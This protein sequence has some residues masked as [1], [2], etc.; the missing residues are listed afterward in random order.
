MKPAGGVGPVPLMVTVV[1]PG[2]V[3]SLKAR[4]VVELGAVVT[5]PLGLTSVF[6]YLAT[7]ILA[8]DGPPGGTAPRRV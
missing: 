6:G 5:D 3:R 2:E 8:N 1:V 4:V 7:N